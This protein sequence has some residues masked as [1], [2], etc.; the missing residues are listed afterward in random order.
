M[1]WGCECVVGDGGGGELKW[2]VMVGSV[3]IAMGLVRVEMEFSV[4][5]QW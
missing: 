2:M 3:G 5:G 1:E 4:C